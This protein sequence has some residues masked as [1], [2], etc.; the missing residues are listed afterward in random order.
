MA[1]DYSQQSDM[2]QMSNMS[3]IMAAGGFNPNKYMQPSPLPYGFNDG[4]SS[5]LPYGIYNG[6]NVAQYL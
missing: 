6:I 3:D 5:P 1:S 2:I 4:I